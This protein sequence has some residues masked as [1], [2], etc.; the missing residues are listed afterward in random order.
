MYTDW[1]KTTEDETGV[2]QK[3]KIPYVIEHFQEMK[4]LDLVSDPEGKCFAGK[5]LQP[6]FETL[7]TGATSNGDDAS[8]ENNS[9]NKISVADDTRRDATVTGKEMENSTFHNTADASAYSGTGDF[10]DQETD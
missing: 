3:T 6:E 9:K 8:A 2:H 1:K 7:K 5:T 4:S 10:V